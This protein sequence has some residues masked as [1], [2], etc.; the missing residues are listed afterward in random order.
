MIARSQIT[1]IALWCFLCIFGCKVNRTVHPI[2]EKE[3]SQWQAYLSLS[4]SS[5][6]QIA[7]PQEPGEPLILCLQF[8]NQSNHS[9]LPD[10]KVLFYQA[11]TQ[12]NY[13]PLQPSDESTARLNGTAITDAEGRIYLTTVLPGDYGSTADNRH[14]HMQVFGAHPEAYDIH[15][16]QFCAPMLK[17]FVAGSNQHFLADLKVVTENQYIAFLTIAVK[18]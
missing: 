6:V 1:S 16:L 4:D 18:N 10:Q 7:S 3:K 5:R 9:P 17:N 12:G 14:I 13:Q 8:I 11:D 2:S 15:F